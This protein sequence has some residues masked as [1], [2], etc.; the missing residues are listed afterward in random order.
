MPLIGHIFW[1]GN[2]TLY[3]K[4]GCILSISWGKGAQIYFCRHPLW[5]HFRVFFRSRPTSYF[6]IFQTYSDDINFIVP[7][8]RPY[9]LERKFNALLETG[10]HFVNIVGE[11]GSNI[12]LSTHPLWRHFRV[13]FRSRPT[14]YFV[15]F[16]TYSDDINFIVSP[17]R[18]YILERKFN[19]LLETGL[20]FVN[21]VGE[22]GSNI[23]LS[24][25]TL[26]AFSSFFRSRPTSYFVIFQTYSDDIN[27]I[28]SPNRPYILERKF[29]ALLETG[30]HFVNFVNACLMQQ[31]KLLLL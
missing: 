24:T 29:N 21:I 23:F 27:F 2:L 16:Q 15:I 30:L 14:S 26:A 31:S 4:L 7:P 5:R 18:P 13:F 12:F 6:V 28:V 17:N 25:P 8:N 10:L 1:S 19:A 9:I 11:R 22:R 3:S 20:H